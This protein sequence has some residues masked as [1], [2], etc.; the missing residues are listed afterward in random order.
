MVA[1]KGKQTV[2]LRDHDSFDPFKWAGGGSGL[3]GIRAPEID[4]DW[5][6]PYDYA[7]LF[8]R[9]AS[10]EIITAGPGPIETSLSVKKDVRNALAEEWLSCRWDM[11]VRWQLCGR[12]DE[13][14]NWETITRLCAARF[15]AYETDG[16]EV[17]TSRAD[18][19]DVILSSPVRAP[20]PLVHFWRLSAR[21]VAIVTVED[22]TV[23]KAC[24]S[25]QCADA[26]GQAKGCTLIIGTTG[27]Y[28]NPGIFVSQ[29]GETWSFEDLD[30]WMGGVDGLHCLGNFVIA[31]S[32]TD[33]EVARSLDLGATWSFVILT[34]PL[35]VAFINPS[36]VVIVGRNG[37]IWRSVNGAASYSVVDAGVAAAGEDLHEVVPVDDLVWWA[38]GDNNTGVRSTD[39]AVTWAAV[40][41]PTPGVDVTAI[42]ALDDNRILVGYADG[43][44]WLSGD[45]GETWEE[46]ESIRGAFSEIDSFAECGCGRIVM[47]GA[48]PLGAGVMYE[49]IDGGA[50]GTWEEHTLPSGVG[51]LDSVTCC[52][53]NLFVAVGEP[54]YPVGG[55]V[56]GVVILS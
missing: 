46:D 50:L 44:L 24:E 22:F 41:M 40:T 34:D 31:V 19:G 3:R 35:D 13:R 49:S 17:I 16:D 5:R 45:G 28:D 52:G 14:T 25:P 7:A 47:V 21:K 27:R 36:R 9:Q 8:A 2:F 12:R 32:S 23:V 20:W 26:T 56:G 15:L 29:D 38:I 53:P 30:H 1:T 18:D 55:T 42:L 51:A 4:V 39:G 33:D 10:L 37:N 43:S 54:V 11:D 48:G 6:D